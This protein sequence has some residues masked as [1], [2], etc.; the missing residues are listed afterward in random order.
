MPRTQF[1]DLDQIPYPDLSFLNERYFFKENL[2]GDLY[3]GKEKRA[4]II[5]SRGCP[6]KCSF[7]SPQSF[8]GGYDFIRLNI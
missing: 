2:L 7:C 8:W 3:C 4:F 6:Y 5:T 1:Q